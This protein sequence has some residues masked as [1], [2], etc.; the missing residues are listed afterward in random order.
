M[1]GPYEPR[2][3]SFLLKEQVCKY[4]RGRVLDM[5]TGTGILAFAA[6]Q[7]AESVVAADI[8]TKALEY[9]EK[10]AKRLGLKID[11]VDSDLFAAIGGKFDLI[12]FN[13]PYL[14]Q[15]KGMVDSE[16]YGGKHGYEL[17]E[18]F[19]I[20]AKDFLKD[21]GKILLLF[22]RLTN[23]NRVDSVIEENL[24]TSELVAERYMFFE[25]LYV[26]L[27]NKS[28]LLKS[29]SHISKLRLET[30][31]RRGLVYSG[32][33]AEQKIAVKVKNPKSTAINRIANE[34]R[35]LEIANRMKIGP[36]I[37]ESGEG[38]VIMGWVEGKRL[39]DFIPLSTK[40]KILE[41]LRDILNQLYRLDKKGVEKGEMHNPVKHIIVG[42][43]PVLVD[44]ERAKFSKK[45]H[46]LTG[47]CQFLC[48]AKVRQLL[49]EKGIVLGNITLE[50]MAYAK[51]RSDEQF[52]AILSC[53]QP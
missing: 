50:A 43:K 21:D 46:N 49:C 1:E 10:E 44:F 41:V 53:L 29:I 22:S 12:I 2:E 14:P 26:Y 45:P 19:L 51:K 39:L 48:S 42:S 20:D 16:I 38:F 27:I 34:A 5:G 11:F 24:Y 36:K 13:P 31:G 8:S 28:G 3:D 33:L 32:E 15:D 17:I 18:R 35:F 40:G 47:F 25:T 30:H 23:K 4:A 6:A 37:I 9:A 7:Q 52:K